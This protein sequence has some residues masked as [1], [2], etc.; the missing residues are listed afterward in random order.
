MAV[1]VARVWLSEMTFTP[2]GIPMRTSR[3]TLVTLAIPLENE[4]TL[5]EIAT[6]HE[7]GLIFAEVVHPNGTRDQIRVT[8][9]GQ[10][11]IH[12]KGDSA[13][14]VF[15][16][17]V[18]ELPLGGM[19]SAKPVTAAFREGPDGLSGHLVTTQETAITL[20]GKTQSHRP[21]AYRLVAGL[22]PD[23]NVESLRTNSEAS[24][25][26]L[27]KGLAGL[28]QRMT[29][30]RDRYTKQGWT[31]IALDAEV[32]ATASR[33]DR[34]AV[35][36][37]IDNKT[38]EFPLDGVVD[39]TLGTISTTGN[40][41][42]G[43][44]PAPFDSN[45]STW[46]LYFRPTYWLLPPRQAGAVTLK[47]KQPAVL[48][49]IRLVNTTN[50]GLNDYAAVTCRVTLLDSEEKPLRSHKVT[51]G[52]AW[53]RVFGAAFA[54]PEFFSSYGKAFAGILEPDVTVP[55]GDPWQELTIDYDQPVHF[56]RVEVE[57]F[58]A[59]GGGLNEIQIYASDKQI[60]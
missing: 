48:K 45:L 40:G 59:L 60:P 9:T 35:S 7:A 11:R 54:K 52:R 47:L 4:G 13:R 15:G 50:A 6:K 41:G 23:P 46:S 12:R 38:W 33:D 53:D 31:N 10:I 5:P 29:D 49:L 39:Y 25:T 28:A 20:A 1:H 55:F 27:R 43:R 24:Q 42:Y 2:R 22:Q 8:E 17:T 57:Q 56:V 58:W 36:H 19:H 30:E 34:F 51:F 14:S 3:D 21:G 18:T 37:V 26:R 44:G 32:S 16:N